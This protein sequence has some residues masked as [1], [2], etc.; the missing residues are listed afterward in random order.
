MT[1]EKYDRALEIV[2]VTML[3]AAGAF[4]AFFIFA[5]TR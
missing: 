1:P 3:L 2:F 4:Y 5:W